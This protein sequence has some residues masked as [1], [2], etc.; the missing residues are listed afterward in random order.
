MAGMTGEIY[1]YSETYQKPIC[2]GCEK[3]NKCYNIGTRLTIPYPDNGELSISG[4]KSLVIDGYMIS[5]IIFSNTQVQFTITSSDGTKIT[6]KMNKGDIEKIFG[7]K[8]IIVKEIKYNNYDGE[9]SSVKFSIR[10]ESYKLGL[11]WRNENYFY[12]GRDEVFV[13]QKITGEIC[14]NDFE[15]QSN[16]CYDRKCEQKRGIKITKIYGDNTYIIEN[17]FFHH[18]ETFY[19]RGLNK[20]YSIGFGKTN[21]DFLVFINDKTYDFK[22]KTFILDKNSQFILNNLLFEESIPSVNITF[23]ESKNPIDN[24]TKL[25]E[26]LS[27]N[28]EEINNNPLQEEISVSITGDVVGENKKPNFFERLLNFFKNLF[29]KK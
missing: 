15:C 5:V 14:E 7:G 13:S 28:K 22:N 27:K 4:G 25:L 9:E 6:D 16:K 20:D 29:S 11:S 3:D 10:G 26:D 1:I 24:S 23:I 17:L 19:F 12:C 8:Y 21:T 18:N 2:N